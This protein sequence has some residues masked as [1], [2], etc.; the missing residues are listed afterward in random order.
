MCPNHI[1]E[2]LKIQRYPNKRAQYL[3]K[4]KRC[5]FF[6]CIT[7]TPLCPRTSQSWGDSHKTEA[8]AMISSAM[9]KLSCDSAALS[10]RL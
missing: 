2:D 9:E 5:L 4:K 1:R 7:V 3:Q 10:Y 6:L 8:S